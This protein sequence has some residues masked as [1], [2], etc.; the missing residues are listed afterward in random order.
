MRKKL[1]VY[2]A[3]GFL[4]SPVF[5]QDTAPAATPRTPTTLR[6]GAF[7]GATTND[8]AKLLTLMNQARSRQ[9]APPLRGDSYLD[10]AAYDHAVLMAKKRELSHQ[11]PGE[12]SLSE[13]LLAGGKIRLDKMGENVAL[14]VTVEGAN[15]HFLHSPP[16]RKNLLDPDFN[17]VGLA[18]VVSGDQI[19]V[20]QDFGRMVSNYSSN[21]AED[22]VANAIRNR[23]QSAGAPPL[24]RVYRG[25]LHEV[26]CAMAREGKLDVAGARPLSQ[27]YHVLKY[28]SPGVDK[29]PEGAEQLIQS[30][31]VAKFSTGVCAAVG[32]N[33]FVIVLLY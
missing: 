19:Y 1:F 28:S 10:A 32:Q 13:R 33:Y 8:K 26:A 29:L 14:D 3:F 22:A 2:L 24:E 21:Q 9:G 20:V 11:F 30:R 31:E 7:S 5:A 4:T 18:I 15:E 16:H 25:D 23:R 12:P 27:N 17:V 6:A